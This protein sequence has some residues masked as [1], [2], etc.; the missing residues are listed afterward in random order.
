MYVFY[1][2]ASGVAAKGRREERQGTVC[3]FAVTFLRPADCSKGVTSSSER[4]YLPFD[5]LA[6]VWS[7]G[8]SGI[9]SGSMCT[10]QVLT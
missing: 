3:A 10:Q 5:K 8:Q 1:G 2:N 6:S 4:G 7:S 9:R